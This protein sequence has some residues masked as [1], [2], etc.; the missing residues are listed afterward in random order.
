MT[1]QTIVLGNRISGVFLS[2][3]YNGN[4]IYIC[5]IP[6]DVETPFLSLNDFYILYKV[7][8]MSGRI[9]GDVFIVLFHS[10]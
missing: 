10:S 4:F 9:G 6:L 3:L 8:V 2:R 1:V 5:N 7:A